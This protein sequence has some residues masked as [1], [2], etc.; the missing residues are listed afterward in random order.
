MT[1]WFAHLLHGPALVVIV[2]LW[3]VKAAAGW[4]LWRGWTA[5]RRR[6]DTG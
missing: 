4:A 1:G 3:P 2:A 5:W 6:G